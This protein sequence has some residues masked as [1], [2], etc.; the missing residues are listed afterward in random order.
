LAYLSHHPRREPDPAG[1]QAG[2]AIDL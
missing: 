1:K 2:S